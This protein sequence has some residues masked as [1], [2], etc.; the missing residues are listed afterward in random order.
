[1]ITDLLSSVHEQ[2]QPELCTLSGIE[3]YQFAP[4]GAAFTKATVTQSGRV[5]KI[6]IYQGNGPQLTQNLIGQQL[7]FNLKS[8]QSQNG[9]IY[10]SGFWND[11]AGNPPPQQPQNTQQAPQ[12]PAQPPNPTQGGD[13]SDARILAFAER[14]LKCMESLCFPNTIPQRP[15][16]PSGPNPDYVGDDPPKPDDP[17][18]P[19]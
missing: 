11:K 6:K 5:A 13:I 14:V 4:S 8:Y 12:Q 1:M 18:I 3:G 7:T 17:E 9:Q 19:F 2:N 15:I 10:I 16:Q